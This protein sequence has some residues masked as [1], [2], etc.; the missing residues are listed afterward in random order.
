MNI[1][2]NFLSKLIIVQLINDYQIYYFRSD[3]LIMM[4]P[5]E[6]TLGAILKQ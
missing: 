6:I 5:I 4:K 3:I 1:K 2:N